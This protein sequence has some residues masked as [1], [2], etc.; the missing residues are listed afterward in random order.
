MLA[1]PEEEPF[2]SGSCAKSE[3]SREQGR[4]AAQ[5]RGLAVQDLP[6]TAFTTN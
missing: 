6:R 4:V 3:V 2:R 1:A 5:L